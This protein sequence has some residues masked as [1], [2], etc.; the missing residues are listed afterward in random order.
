MN[1]GIVSMRNFIYLLIFLFVTGAVSAQDIRSYD[2]H[3][4]NLANPEWGKAGEQLKRV[5][6]ISYSDYIAA[7]GGT[8][9]MNPRA[10]SNVMFAQDE[11]ISDA[12]NLSDY[13]WV[14]GQFID[15]D[16]SLTE[17]SGF[18]PAFVTVPEGDKH[19]TPGANILMFRSEAM[20]G[21]GTS[22][23]NPR[24]NPNDVTAFIDGSQV[25]GSDETRANWL[26]TRVDGKLKISRGNLLPWNTTTG[27]F[28]DSELRELVN[29]DAYGMENNSSADNRSSKMFVAGDRRANENPLLIS[30]HTLFVREHNR[31]CDKLLEADPSLSDEDLYQK[32]RKIVGGTIQNIVYSEWLPAQGVTLPDYTGYN[33]DMD[34]SIF[35]V[36]SAAAFRLGH[37]LINSTILRMDNNGDEIPRGNTDLR[38][39]FFQP[40]ELRLAGGI[41]SYLIGMA[42]Q[43][44]Q[45]FDCKVI[46][47]VRNFLFGEPSEGGLDLAAIN[48]NRGRERGLPDYNTVRADFGLP[49]VNTFMDIT[50]DPEGARLLDQVYGG[51]ID[52]IDPWVGMLSEYHMP[53]ALFGELIM[54][55]IE[56]Q[57]QL[58]RDGDR[59]YFENDPDLS[60]DEKE[61]IR[62]TSFRDVIMNNTEIEIMQENVFL[63]MP[64]NEIPNG[65]TIAEENLNSTIYPNPTNSEFTIKFYLEEEKQTT[66][67]VYSPNGSLITS[68]T[69][70]YPAGPNFISYDLRENLAKGLYHILIESGF[71]YKVHKL[72]K[73]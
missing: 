52:N 64:H 71:D 2:G 68:Q 14:F 16:I 31:L 42:T 40:S 63:A 27:E 23:D 28:N 45:E 38:S 53:N 67:R 73:E 65:P 66:F 3:G 59:F 62:N 46:D 13:T 44:E 22:I 26:R 5:T 21:T 29:S 9:R 24:Q 12:L 39:S 48:I 35:N 60:H 47:D 18:E 58:L 1:V 10:I 55:I 72:V 33:P 17:S 57:F 19:F 25:Y 8:S 11:V 34:P 30:F 20:H 37:T 15:H 7:P 32:A 43:I 70:T 36:F 61:M 4:N 69:D 6:E 54:T 41:D 51:D 56:R 50:N 49:R